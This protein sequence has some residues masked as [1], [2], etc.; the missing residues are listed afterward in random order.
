MISYLITAG[1]TALVTSIFYLYHYEICNPIKE[2]AEAT[3]PDLKHEWF[4]FIRANI[5]SAYTKFH[6]HQ[7]AK[8]IILFD[9]RFRKEQPS[10]F[11]NEWIEILYNLLDTR[12]KTLITEEDTLSTLTSD[13]AINML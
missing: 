3:R 11:F 8:L 9:L 10:E 5:N 1:I 4:D 6:C 7:V 12:Y 2:E 13:D